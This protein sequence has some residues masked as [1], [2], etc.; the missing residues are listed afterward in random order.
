MFAHIAYSVQILHH[1]WAVV[2]ATDT[3]VI[4]MCMYCITH[5]D[6]LQELWVKTMDISLPVHAIT[7][8]LAG[9]Y[10]VAASDLTSLLL[11]T[12]ILTRCDSKTLQAIC[13]VQKMGLHNCY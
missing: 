2:V 9:K 1:T 6:G 4:M 5:M 10:D 8:A 12:Y 7:E 11:S 13:T 3:D